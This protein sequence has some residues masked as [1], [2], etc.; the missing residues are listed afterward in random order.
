[1]KV[2]INN[3][4]FTLHEA[5]LFTYVNTVELY[6]VNNSVDEIIEAIGDSATVIIP[7]E[8]AHSDLV[9]DYVKRFWD[10]SGSVCE[11]VFKP[12]PVKEIIDQ[13]SEDLE[14]ISGA[15]EEL[16]ELISGGE[17]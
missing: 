11:V 4:E 6:I 15:I 1:M 16:A 3:V 2:L 7:N 8:Y 10:A 5:R 9:L 17:N 14:I 13:H 12:V